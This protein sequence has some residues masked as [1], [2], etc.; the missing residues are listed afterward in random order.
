MAAVAS[1]AVV[2]ELVP[3]T[4]LPLRGCCAQLRLQLQPAF[5]AAFDSN[6]S[7][8]VQAHL[9]ESIADFFEDA[10]LQEYI[11]S[12]PGTCV[13]CGSVYRAFSQCLS[14]GG[15]V[16]PDDGSFH[17]LFDDWVPGPRPP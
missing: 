16:D 17:F 5:A 11:D 14:C 12:Y 13:G 9:V 8:V 2:A 6:I 10:L 7:E 3:A 1:L 15:P 4:L